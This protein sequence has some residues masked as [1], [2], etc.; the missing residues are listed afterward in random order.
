MDTNNTISLPAVVA[1]FLGAA[2]RFDA[3]AAAACFTSDA[4]FRDN[5]REF[6]G[7]AAIERLMTES[8]EVRPH[9]TVT[10]AK[11]DGTT[12]GIVGTVVGNFPESPVELDFEF[13]LQD[14]KI[15]QL[16]VS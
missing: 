9:I 12:A 3:V 1:S 2:N 7:T 4:T 11:V 15:S 8:N 13:Q 5:G 14:G 16:T 10:S 6:I